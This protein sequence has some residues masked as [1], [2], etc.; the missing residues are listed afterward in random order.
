MHHLFIKRGAK[1]FDFCFATDDYYNKNYHKLDEYN[2]LE[3]D[4]QVISNGKFFIFYD[5]VYRV[6]QA[7]LKMLFEDELSKVDSI[8]LEDVR[9]DLAFKVK[10]TLSDCKRLFYDDKGPEKKEHCSGNIIIVNGENAYHIRANFLICDLDLYFD[11]NDTSVLALDE[12]LGNKSPLEIMETFFDRAEK[13][14]GYCS[15]PIVYG[16]TE[17]KKIT[18]RTFD[19]E[20]RDC[21]LE[22]FVCRW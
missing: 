11:D 15:Y 16:N 4:L 19:K 1:G 18:L 7:F 10:K 13:N 17:K 2:G 3:S 22:E 8:S 12:V 6:E 5:A 14:H 20:T 21:E 9:S